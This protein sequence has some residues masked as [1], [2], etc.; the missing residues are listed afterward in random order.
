[1]FS[2]LVVFSRDRR[3]RTPRYPRPRCPRREIRDK[4]LA[5]NH[6]PG[7]EDFEHLA[8]FLIFVVFI[9]VG[10]TGS[11]IVEIIALK[12]SDMFGSERSCWNRESIVFTVLIFKFLDDLPAVLLDG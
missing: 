10:F 1:M 2:F 4:T 8:C 7:K 6:D 9:P 11:S 12:S 3:R 5:R